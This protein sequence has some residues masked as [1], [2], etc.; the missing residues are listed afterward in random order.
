MGQ[1]PLPRRPLPAPLTERHVENHHEHE[2]YRKRNRA[3]VAV[4]ALGHFGDELLDDH[5]DHRTRRKREQIGHHR[6]DSA[7]RKYRD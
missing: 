4:N 7:R 1:K 6:Y 3:N 2:P 5:V